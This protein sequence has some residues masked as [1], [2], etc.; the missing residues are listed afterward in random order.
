MELQVINN[1]TPSKQIFESTIPIKAIPEANLTAVILGDFLEWVCGTLSLNEDGAQKLE[2]ALPAIKKHCWSMG[3]AEIKKM[4]NMYADGE[5]SIKPIPNHFDRI[6]LGEVMNA[7]RQQ[8]PRPKP[9][10]PKEMSEDE[11]EQIVLLGIINCFE[12]YKVTKE[13]KTGYGYVYD[14]FFEKGN[15]PT[16]TKEFK[17]QIKNKAVLALEKEITA[18]GITLQVK[19][20]LEAMRDGLKGVK[21]KCK[22]IILSEYF[23]KLILEGKEITKEL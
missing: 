18:L 23:D 14:Y 21:G 20:Q 5:L 10:A 6:R 16:H 9:E 8:K 7:Y 11:K 12:D 15:L 22:Q 13:I 4:L 2:Y 1:N 17:E 19:E 3:F